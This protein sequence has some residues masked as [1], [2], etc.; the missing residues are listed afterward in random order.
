MSLARVSGMN[1]DRGQRRGVMG[2]RYSVVVLEGLRPFQR[3]QRGRGRSLWKAGGGSWG[4]RIL[5]GVGVR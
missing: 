1:G 2:R 3:A 5:R 4:G